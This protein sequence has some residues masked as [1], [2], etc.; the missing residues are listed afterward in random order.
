MPPSFTR[1]SLFKYSAAA[2]ATAGV[3]AG[4]YWLAKPRIRLGLIGSGTRG[5]QLARALRLIGVRD[6]VDDPKLRRLKDRLHPIS[7]LSLTAPSRMC[8]SHLGD[9]T[10]EPT[11]QDDPAAIGDVPAAGSGSLRALCG[12]GGV[13]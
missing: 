13:A 12:V 11:E 6:D 5:T 8:S 7:R 3:A 1:R 9:A 2:I 10:Y 4:G